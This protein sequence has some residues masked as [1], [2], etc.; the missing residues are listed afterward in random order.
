[1]D[2]EGFARGVRFAD[3][4]EPPQPD[5]AG[6]A[7]AVRLDLE[8][9]EGLSA[10]AVG[11]PEPGPGDAERRAQLERAAARRNP[12]AQDAL[13]AVERDPGS[14]RRAGSGAGD[15]KKP[16]RGVDPDRAAAAERLV[17]PRGVE[18]RR[19]GADE[20]HAAVEPGGRQR[21]APIP[22]RRTLAF[23][24]AVDAGHRPVV[25][26]RGG[27]LRRL[28]V[29]DFERAAAGRREADLQLVGTLPQKFFGVEAPP[30][31]LVVRPADAAAVHENVGEGVDRVEREQDRTAPKQPG[32]HVEGPGQ[33]PIPVR[34]PL[35][36]RFVVA[37]MRVGNPPRRL[38][39]GI[40]VSRDRTGNRFGLVGG[41]EP[42]DAGEGKGPI[43]EVCS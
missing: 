29:V 21:Q 24:D 20:R 13:L 40:V 4:L 26:V 16:D 3:H 37:P 28:G 10:V 22:A 17:A 12:P 43:E 15:G 19:V 32:G 33:N 41:A 39:R 35:D 30:A 38:E 9:V 1:M 25:G 42:P 14:D 31:E 27:Q 2:R 6:D 5:A 23:A 11:P 8:V 7:L 18:Q 34:D 36:L